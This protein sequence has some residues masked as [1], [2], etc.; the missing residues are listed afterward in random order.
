MFETDVLIK[1]QSHPD[2][3]KFLVKLSSQEL[4]LFKQMQ[5]WPKQLL[6]ILESHPDVLKFLV[7]I[8]PSE[9]DEFVSLQQWQTPMLTI[10][11]DHPDLIRILHNAWNILDDKEAF[12]KAYSH[13]TALPDA[14]GVNI[15]DA[16]SQGQLASKTWLLDTARS[17]GLEFNNAWTLCGWIGTL[18]YL[19]LSRSDQLHL[20]SVRSFDID[21]RCASLA[22]T[23]NKTAVKDGWKFKATT[24][25]VNQITYDDFS[26]QTRKYDGSLQTV[27]DSADTIINTSCDHMG[28]D[29]TWWDKIPSGKLVILQNNNWHENDQHNNSVTDL[30]EFKRMYIMDE[31]LFAGELDCTLYTRFMLIGRK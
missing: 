29:N 31:L 6:A 11:R 27:I 19:M 26:Y 14:D 22:D 4:D 18:G 3:L 25:D 24:M 30:N 1:L 20:T 17:L 7:K 15:T 28:N 23:L 16:F 21:D 2:V 13:M 8:S 5:S 12:C 9:S 10:M